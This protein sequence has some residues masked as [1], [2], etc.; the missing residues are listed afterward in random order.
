SRDGDA[1]RGTRR[2]G[3]HAV[4]A[5]AVVVVGHVVP[6]VDDPQVEGPL[7]VEGVGA[8]DPGVGE[9]NRVAK[10]NRVGD[11]VVEVVVALDHLG[12]VQ[13]DEAT[14][15]QLDAGTDGDGVREVELADI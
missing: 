11:V 6:A 12:A 8:H 1:E 5:L 3:Q 13:G 7:V 2:P 14:R 4:H 10:Q 9:R 15:L